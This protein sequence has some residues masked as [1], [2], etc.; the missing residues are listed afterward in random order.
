MTLHHTA[1][2]ATPARWPDALESKSFFLGS[3]EQQIHFLPEGGA[4]AQQSDALLASVLH[5]SF[6]ESAT[7]HRGVINPAL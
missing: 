1:S 4:I 5:Y 2:E 6:I 7:E 3:G